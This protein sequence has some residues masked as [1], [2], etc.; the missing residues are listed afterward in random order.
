MGTKNPIIRGGVV[1]MK[2]A[3]G[4]TTTNSVSNLTSG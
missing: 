4:A 2:T 3:E 1:V